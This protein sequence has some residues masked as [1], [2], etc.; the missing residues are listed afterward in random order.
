[1]RGRI[2]YY[3][4]NNHENETAATAA[5]TLYLLYYIFLSHII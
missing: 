3:G 5:A 1:M 2:R 4:D